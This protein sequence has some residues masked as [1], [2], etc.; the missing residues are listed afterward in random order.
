MAISSLIVETAPENTKRVADEVAAFE[1]AEVQAA[2]EASGK[3][4][5]VLEAESIEASHAIASQFAAINGVFGVN[6]VYVNVEDELEAGT[7]NKIA[8]EHFTH[9]TEQETEQD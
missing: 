5:V 9:L 4:V 7:S 2:D 3:I 8:D 6:L 1:G